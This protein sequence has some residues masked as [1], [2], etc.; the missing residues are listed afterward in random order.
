MKICTLT[1][2]NEVFNALHLDQR[3]KLIQFEKRAPFIPT[4]SDYAFL[5]KVVSVLK[6]KGIEDLHESED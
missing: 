5:E 6:E 3:I 2:T 1:L 4:E